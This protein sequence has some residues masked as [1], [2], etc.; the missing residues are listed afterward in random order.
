MPRKIEPHKCYRKGCNNTTTNPKFCSKSC[1]TKVNNSLHPKREKEGK[2]KVCG[3]PIHSSKVHCKEHTKKLNKH[4]SSLKGTFIAD[5]SEITVYDAIYGNKSGLGASNRYT[6][7]RDHA[8]RTYRN[9]DKPKQCINCGYDKHYHVCHIKPIHMF[10]LESTIDVVNHIDNL[11]ALC[12][13]C[14]WELDNGLLQL[15]TK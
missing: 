6:R 9:S 2:C 4:T 3:K 8:L 7:I 14:H 1:A 5:W 11:T 13:N 10:S 12:P 15:S